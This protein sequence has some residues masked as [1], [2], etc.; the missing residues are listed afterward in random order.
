MK[1]VDSVIA[2]VGAVA[3]AHPNDPALMADGCTWTYR[4]LWARTETYARAV[5][6]S[7]A[8]PGDVVGLIGSNEP[9]YLAAYL[10]IMR[11]GCATAAISTMIAPSSVRAQLAAAGAR[12]VITGRLADDT[13]DALAGDYLLLDL[14]EPPTGAGAFDLPEVGPD[15]TAIIMMTSGSSGE[16]KGAQHT[17]ASLFH[18]VWQMAS[19]FPH[20][21]GDRGV[22]FLPLYT[23]T[24]EQALPTLCTGGSLDI[25]PG[26]DPERVAD[27]CVH[28]TTFDAVPT[29]MS[30]LLEHA[31]LHKLA[32]LRWILFASEPMPVHLLQRWWD[33]L[34]GVETHQFYGMTELLTLTAAPHA[35]LRQVPSTVGRAFPSTGIVLDPVEGH[36]SD[37]GEIVASSPSCMRGYL[38]NPAATDAALTSE[39]ALRTGDIG[40]FD[41]RG[42]L[43]LTGRVK[44]IIISG[45][46][47]IAPAEIET[48]AFANPGVREAVVVGIPSDRWG[49]T[50][51]VVAVPTAGSALTAMDLLRDCRARLSTYKRPS[52]AALVPTLPTTGI[53][54]VDKVRVKKM[55]ESGEIRITT[56]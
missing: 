15:T 44:D 22:V 24:P 43:Y 42:L 40:R 56:P 9:A 54:K 19:A 28:A 48:V 27:A 8:A 18:A 46:F 1:P 30:R 17:H 49:E 38:N 50:P 26:F 6:S 21:R 11:A 37:E 23:C 35:L 36:G 31:P 55:I 12:V 33:E 2:Q 45:G 39:H 16:P 7:G 29:I 32:N 10:G 47:N 53:G 14:A 52:A 41:E 5:L 25:L 20:H 13:R 51:V 3:R 4:E 34:P